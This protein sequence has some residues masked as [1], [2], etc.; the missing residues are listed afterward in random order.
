MQPPRCRG[1]YW[2]A[3]C[4]IV[5]LAL[6]SSCRRDDGSHASGNDGELRRGIRVEKPRLTKTTFYESPTPSITEL[7][8]IASEGTA[9]RND[10]VAIVDQLSV[11]AV[12]LLTRQLIRTVAFDRA[13]ADWTVIP[14]AHRNWQG[15]LC[16]GDGG[17]DVILLSDEGHVQWALPSRDYRWGTVADLD[18]DGTYEVYVATR[19]EI[20]ALDMNGHVRWSTLNSSVTWLGGCSSAR[21]SANADV[22]VGLAGN[23]TVLI[24]ARDGT[25]LR[26]ISLPDYFVAIRVVAWPALGN[27]P[28]VIGL[29]SEGNGQSLQVLSLQGVPKFSYELPA[30]FPTAIDLEAT[31]VALDSDAKPYLAVLALFSSSTGLG[32]LSLFDANGRLAYQEVVGRSRGILAIAPGRLPTSPDGALLVGE[33]DP[34]RVSI[35]SMD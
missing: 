28:Y 11:Q 13:C 35:Y 8:L 31:T 6:I 22:L 18:R 16:R 4:A 25:F 30:Q 19:Q 24:I 12:G 17:N 23:N 7:A 34:R 26:A 21:D 32:F 9:S 27:G 10:S 33:S 3:I 2:C 29:T 15:F 14:G 5:A 1:A 20:Q